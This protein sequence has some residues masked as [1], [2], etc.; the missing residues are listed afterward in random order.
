[1]AEVDAAARPA[2]RPADPAVHPAVRHGRP[3]SRL[4]QGLRPRHPRERRPVHPRRDLG[5]RWPTALQGRGDR[6]DELFDILNPVRHAADPAGG[7]ALQ[8]RALRR[9]GRRLRPPA[10]R[11]PGRL[12]L[13]HR[14]GRLALPGRRSRTSSASASGA[15]GSRSTRASRAD[16]PGFE[17]T[18]RH[19]SATYRIVVENPHGVERGV[20]RSRSTASPSDGGRSPWSTTA[21]STRSAS[22]SATRRGRREV[23]SQT[24]P[25]RAVRHR[26]ARL[27]DICASIN[28]GRGPEPRAR[29]LCMGYACESAKTGRI[30]GAADPQGTP[31]DSVVESAAG[32]EAPL[33]GGG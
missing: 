5:R 24:S 9:R 25:S 10:P 18:Y 8:G 17:L 13:V 27:D 3:P 31:E 15:T 6:A 23:G 1:M 28:R 29:G 11:R 32:D 4:H 33:S 19:G 14:L 7:R 21:A 12:D 30:G 26:T 16:W 22:P 20:A 2:R